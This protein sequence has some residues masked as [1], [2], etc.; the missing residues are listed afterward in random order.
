MDDKQEA[1]ESA[2]VLQ[3]CH[4]PILK[5]KE[6]LETQLFVNEIKLESQ[7]N[8][9]VGMEKEFKVDSHTPTSAVCSK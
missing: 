4:P 2:F 1:P 9:K 3:W 6:E 7:A 8:E 5:V